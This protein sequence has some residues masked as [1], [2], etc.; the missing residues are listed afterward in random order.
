MFLIRVAP[1]I[2][3]PPSLHQ[4]SSEM[5]VWQQPFFPVNNKSLN[6]VKS[7]GE[8][9]REIEVS[10]FALVIYGILRNKTLESEREI[11]I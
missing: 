5:P 11:N 4:L 1:W 6:E 8:S 9:D 7:T 10:I 3:F 2:Y